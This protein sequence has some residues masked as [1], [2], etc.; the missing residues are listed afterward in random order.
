MGLAAVVGRASAWFWRPRIRRRLE[1]LSGTVLVGL[2]V[3]VAVSSR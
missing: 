3:R 1:A 2:G